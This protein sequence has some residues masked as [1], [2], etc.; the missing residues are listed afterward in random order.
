MLATRFGV[1]AIDAV[2]DGSF[3]QMV[4][5]R[6]GAIE[7]V[8]LQEATARLKPVGRELLDVAYTFFA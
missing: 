6:G 4:A 3:G 2:H 1:A 8:S 7:L 5:L